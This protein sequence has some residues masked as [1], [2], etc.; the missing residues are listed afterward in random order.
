MP[1][2]RGADRGAEDRALGDR[3]V[4]DPVSAE[5]LLQSTRAAEDA[6]GEADV[7]AVD[8]Q[9]RPRR[10]ARRVSARLTACQNVISSARVVGARSVRAG[11][12]VA[13]TWSRAV[14]GSGF[15]IA[16][17]FLDDRVQ[18]GDGLASRA[19]RAR[20]VGESGPRRSRARRR[21]S[22]SRCLAAFLVLG[23]PVVLDVA[24]VVGHQRGPSSPRSASGPVRPALSPLRLRRPSA[25][26]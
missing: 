17:D 12:G 5:L 14:A 4:E 25:T 16:S 22:G 13:A 1:F 3:R 23:R 15:G 7:F 19:L 24:V 2:D 6:A 26:A 8:E 21:G 18:L 11:A 9:L 20:D 10:R